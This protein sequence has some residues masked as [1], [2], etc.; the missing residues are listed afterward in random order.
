VHTKSMLI[1]GKRWYVHHD[2]DWKGPVLVSGPFDGEMPEDPPLPDRY[3]PEL[4][5]AVV[6]EMVLSY[7]K[8]RLETL[9]MRELVGLPE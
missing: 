6:A 1:N 4:F 9:S 8:E 5:I 7:R 2:S 3:P